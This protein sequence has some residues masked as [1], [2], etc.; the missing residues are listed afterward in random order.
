MCGLRNR[1]RRLES[2]AIYGGLTLLAFWASFGPAA[3]LYTMLYEVV[4]GFGLLRAP[5]RFALV[6]AFGL[7][8]FAGIAI[9]WLLERVPRALAVACVLAVLTAA[10]LKVPLNLPEAQPVEPVY[11]VLATLPRGAVIEMPFFYPASRIVS[12]H[13]IH[14]RVDRALDAARQRIQRLHPARLSTIT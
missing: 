1:A 4:P 2:L 14:G 8:V 11:R 10:E 7:A 12:T 5:G 9:G 13:E 3:G 6:V